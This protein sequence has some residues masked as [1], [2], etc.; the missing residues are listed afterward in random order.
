MTNITISLARTK[1]DENQ[2]CGVCA[3][4][5]IPSEDSGSRLFS[6]TSPAENAFTALLCG[7]C[8]SKWS[9]GTT[10]TFRRPQG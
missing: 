4:M 2:P 10:V 6:M 8:F 7:G 3:A 5:F 1:S 9:H